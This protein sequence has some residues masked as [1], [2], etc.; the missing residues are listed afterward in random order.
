MTKEAAYELGMQLALKHAGFKIALGVGGVGSRQ[1]VSKL[2][3]K[4]QG[5]ARIGAVPSINKP[6]TKLPLMG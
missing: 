6:V 5:L 1:G 4:A 2:T 3:P